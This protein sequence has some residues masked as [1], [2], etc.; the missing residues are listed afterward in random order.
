METDNVGQERRKN[1]CLIF[2]YTPSE[3]NME[4]LLFLW[5]CAKENRKIQPSCAVSF[6]N[7]WRNVYLSWIEGGILVPLDNEPDF[8][9]HLYCLIILSS[10]NILI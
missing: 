6:M 5:T 1:R 10:G 9:A 7:I 8:R 3:W 4:E 2:S